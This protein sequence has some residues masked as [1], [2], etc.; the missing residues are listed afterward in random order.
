MET[1]YRSTT[2]AFIAMI[3]IFV[4]ATCM[5][6]GRH[7]YSISESDRTMLADEIDQTKTLA[8]RIASETNDAERLEELKA[9]VAIHQERLDQLM[10]RGPESAMARILEIV[11]FGGML[12]S[13]FANGVYIYRNA[14]H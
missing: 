5:F 14:V 1:R 11:A 6:I 4:A 2:S 13:I 10:A 8:E 9:R 7:F 3:A 12:I